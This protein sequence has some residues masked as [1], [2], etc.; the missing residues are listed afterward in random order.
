MAKPKRFP[1]STE[2]SVSRGA[3]ILPTLKLSLQYE[4]GVPREITGVLD[5][6]ATVNVLPYRAG[7]E[8]GATWLEHGQ[9]VDLTGNLGRFEARPLFVRAR[10]AGFPP[11]ELAFAWT[12]AEGIPM[13][14]G[15]VNFFSEFDVCFYR[16]KYAFDIR[17]ADAT[18]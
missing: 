10:V 3:A 18:V 8:L 6:G 16:S 11:V 9:S 17:P 13:I 4:N 1:Y 2:P 14:L 12:Q 15:Q 7:L 5:T